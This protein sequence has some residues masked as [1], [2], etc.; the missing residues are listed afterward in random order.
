VLVMVQ[1]AE[2][3]ASALVALEGCAILR[4]FSISEGGP[5]AGCRS[6]FASCEIA[7]RSNFNE[8]S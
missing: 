5:R 1:S 7:S 3:S 4:H 8:A 6:P 2:A